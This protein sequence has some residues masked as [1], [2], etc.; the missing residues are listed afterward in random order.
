VPLVYGTAWYRPHT[1]VTALAPVLA[2]REIVGGT[3]THGSPVAALLY[4]GDV[5]PAPIT[6]LAEQLDGESLFGRRI[7]RI[8]AATFDAHAAALDISTI[9]AIEDDA[10]RLVFLADRPEYRRVIVPP[11]VV[12]MA[13]RSTRAGHP[14]ARRAAA[15]SREIA[16]RAADAGGWLDGG[17]AYSP[18][19][20]AERDGRELPTRRGRYGTL[21]V[22]APPDGGAIR[23]R[24][25]PGIVDVVG[26]VVSA[27]AAVALAADAWRRRSA[28]RELGAGGDPQRGADGVGGVEDARVQR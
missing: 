22:Q 6:R 13:D 12:F 2:G 26:V 1:H 25:G 18:L 4:R 24:Y 9:V 19:W 8:D 3:F 5:S 20:Q 7:D 28:P 11:F 27:M 23:L 21:E 15:G 10:P 16:A 14:A 17:V